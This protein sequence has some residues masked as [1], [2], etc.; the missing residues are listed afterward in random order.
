MLE[1]EVGRGW[2]LGQLPANFWLLMGAVHCC[3]SKHAITQL[4]FSVCCMFGTVSSVCPFEKSYGSN[5]VILLNAKMLCLEI[6][7]FFA[8]VTAHSLAEFGKYI[9]DIEDLRERMVSCHFTNSI[10]VS[11]MIVKWTE[12]F[13][14][15]VTDD[16]FISCD[17]TIQK[18]K[19]EEKRRRNKTHVKSQ[20][21]I[22]VRCKCIWCTMKF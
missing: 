10:I 1:A 5:N 14:L 18:I 3:C 21:H 12:M 13:C 20:W 2:C 22:T 8:L 11:V 9:S 4:M 16:I 15:F 7:E 17:S 19:D 6:K